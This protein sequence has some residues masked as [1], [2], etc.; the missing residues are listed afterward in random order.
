MS[1]PS[2]ARLR[3]RLVRRP[4]GLGS[5]AVALIA[6]SAAAMAA[7]AKVGEGVFNRES[8]PFDER[9]PRVGT[10]QSE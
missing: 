3:P 10:A 5:H 7:S 2:T 4:L 9:E 1:T 8:A 6:A